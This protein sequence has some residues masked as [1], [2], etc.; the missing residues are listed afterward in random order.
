MAHLRLRP[1][2]HRGDATA[3]SRTLRPDGSPRPLA[4]PLPSG[5]IGAGDSLHPPANLLDGALAPDV[6]VEGKCNAATSEARSRIARVF[7]GRALFGWVSLRSVACVCAG[8]SGKA[9][10]RSLE[11]MTGFSCPD[12]R[13]SCSAGSQQPPRPGTGP[14]ASER[15]LERDID[16]VAASI[17]V[18]FGASAR[19]SHG[20]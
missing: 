19:A 5:G 4:L 2:V 10:T 8:G 17:S 14:A 6:K 7:N 3:P 16:V 1:H 18:E 11:Q 20:C 9:L 13:S 12:T 15:E